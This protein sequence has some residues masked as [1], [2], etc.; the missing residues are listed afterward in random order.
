MPNK[1]IKNR[2]V[3]E[4]HWLQLTAEETTIPEGAA[5]IPL[6]LWQAHKEQ[7]TDRKQLGIWLDS[8]ESPNLI[9]DDLN[10][11][12]VVAINFPSFADGRGFSYARELREQHD[13]QGEIRAIGHFMRDQ[14]FYLQRCG[15]NAF[16][17]EGSEPEQALNSLD[18]FSDSYQACIDQ[19]TPL[20]KRR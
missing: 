17:L 5:I 9:A 13:Y 11:F 6:A 3:V 2:E 14:L 4:D 8:D 20:F 7:L 1:L 12:D 16:A 19:A 15:F 18:D 10:H